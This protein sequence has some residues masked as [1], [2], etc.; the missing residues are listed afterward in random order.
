MESVDSNIFNLECKSDFLRLKCN[1]KIYR[2]EASNF[3]IAFVAI[4]LRHLV[5]LLCETQFLRDII[6]IYNQM[7][8][9]K[10]RVGK[11]AQG[12]KKNPP[13]EVLVFFKQLLI[14]FR[15]SWKK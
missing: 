1:V 11:S 14:N 13:S 4:V 10:I 6:T 9:I 8:I 7:D 15:V 12:P 2:R 3:R 5:F